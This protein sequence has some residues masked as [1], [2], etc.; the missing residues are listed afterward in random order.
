MY[1]SAPYTYFHILRSILQRALKAV[2]NSAIAEF[3]I[4][5]RRQLLHK[6]FQSSGHH[7][8]FLWLCPSVDRMTSSLHDETQPF[9]QSISSASCTNQMCELYKV[10]LV[11]TP[12]VILTLAI[13]ILASYIFLS[14]LCLSVWKPMLFSPPHGSVL[15]QLLRPS[16][17]ANQLVNKGAHSLSSGVSL[18]ALKTVCLSD[19]MFFCVVVFVSTLSLSK[20]NATAVTS[21]VRLRALQYLNTS[22]AFKHQGQRQFIH[23]KI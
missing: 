7:S 21:L 12:L 6:R 20:A 22:N 18:G 13:A 8:T 11:L 9:L 10:F 19:Q 4:D 1:S 14:I 16:R 2:A 17:E 23:V 3:R 15:T 5:F